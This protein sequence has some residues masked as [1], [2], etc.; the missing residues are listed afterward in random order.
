MAFLF[1]VEFDYY[2]N[3]NNSYTVAFRNG[4]YYE[5]AT[6]IGFTIDDFE[7]ANPCWKN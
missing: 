2:L 6:S 7:S 5:M 4:E 1:D 3:I